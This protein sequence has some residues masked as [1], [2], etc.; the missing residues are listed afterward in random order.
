MDSI[1]IQRDVKIDFIRSFG[2]KTLASVFRE[3]V[4][5]VVKMINNE[6]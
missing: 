5:T 2:F 3:Y 6:L 4:R 1:R